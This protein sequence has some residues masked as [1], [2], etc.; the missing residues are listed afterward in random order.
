[1]LW[2]TKSAV[3]LLVFLQTS[4]TWIPGGGKSHIF[5][6]DALTL[7]IKPHNKSNDTEMSPTPCAYISFGESAIHIPGTWN[8]FPTERKWDGK[9]GRSFVICTRRQFNPSSCCPPYYQRYS[10]LTVFPMDFL[11]WTSTGSSCFLQ[12]MEQ[13]GQ[14]TMEF[15]EVVV[16]KTPSAMYGKSLIYIFFGKSLYT[17]R[18]LNFK[19]KLS[20]DFNHAEFM[21]PSQADLRQKSLCL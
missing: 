4:Q 2:R 17:V 9:E 8:Y 11:I 1:M 12:A 18:T 7:F 15:G 21:S 13:S 10:L 14:Q 6:S 19:T 3:S 5:S 16:W 20:F